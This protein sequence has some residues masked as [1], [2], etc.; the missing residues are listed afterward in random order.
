MKIIA[1]FAIRFYQKNLRHLHNRRCIYTPSCSNYGIQ[2][3]EKY[4]TIKGCYFIY[5][6]IKRCNGAIFKGGEDYP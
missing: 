6:R 2:A 4:G 1:I 5:S 3:I